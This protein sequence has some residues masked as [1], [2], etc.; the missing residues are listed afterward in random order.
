M[1]P[2]GNPNKCSPNKCKIKAKNHFFYTLSKCVKKLIISDKNPTQSLPLNSMLNFMKVK[3]KLCTLVFITRK[4][5]KPK[6]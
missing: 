4:P 2:K 3:Q 5:V 6:N 1:D